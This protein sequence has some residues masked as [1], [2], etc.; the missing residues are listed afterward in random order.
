MSKIFS[1]FES[2]DMTYYLTSIDTF[3]LSRVVILDIRLTFLIFPCE[4]YFN[5]FL[6]IFLKNLFI[7]LSKYFCLLI[8]CLGF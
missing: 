3:S 7:F 4:Y 1:L 6:I 8:K 2:L 5:I